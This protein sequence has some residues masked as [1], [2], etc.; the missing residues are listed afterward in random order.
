MRLFAVI[1]KFEKLNCSLLNADARE[2]RGTSRMR[3]RSAT[4][5]IIGLRLIVFVEVGSSAD[6]ANVM[7]RW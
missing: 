7:D 3:C 5:L 6:E 2:R 1:L 4:G